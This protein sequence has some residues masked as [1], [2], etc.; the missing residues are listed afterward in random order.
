MATSYTSGV[1][2][3]FRPSLTSSQIQYL[4]GILQSSAQSQDR[5]NILGQL[6]K[7]HLKATHGIVSPSHISTP[8]PSLSDSLGFTDSVQSSDDILA[9]VE[10]WRTNPTIL[11][12]AQL[13]RVNHHRY[14]NDMMTVEEEANYEASNY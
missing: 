1:S 13:T 5:D 12:P 10:I 9:L 4:I 14:I 3:K 8:R 11:S 7:F 6:H 2:V